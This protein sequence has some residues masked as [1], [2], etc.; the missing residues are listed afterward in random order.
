MYSNI[1]IFSPT[2]VFNHKIMKEKLFGLVGNHL[3]M[4]SVKAFVC[5]K[6]RF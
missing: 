4:F 1:F 6:L 2:H 3:A 5:I